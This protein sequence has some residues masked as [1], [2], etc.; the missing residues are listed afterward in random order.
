[1]GE[2]SGAVTRRLPIDV[3]AVTVNGVA[4]DAVAHVVA[5]RPG[6]IG[7]WRGPVAGV[8]NV[9]YLGRWDAVPRAH[10]N[11]GR[12]DIVELDSSTT[13]RQRWQM[14]A[15]LPSGTHLPHPALRTRRAASAQ[16]VFGEPL[17][18]AVDG[19]VVGTAEMVDVEIRPDAACVYV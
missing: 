15:R 4:H 17:E 16:L 9:E 14:R 5:R 7:W 8:F 12:L 18:V 2:P 19:V 11:D 1:M 10:P 6:T 13:P 3:I